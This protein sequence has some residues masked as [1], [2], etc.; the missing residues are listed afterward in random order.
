MILL[1]NEP[2][3]WLILRSS[4]LISNFN[5]YTIQSPG[6]IFFAS[7]QLGDLYSS[8]NVQVEFSKTIWNHFNYYLFTHRFCPILSFP[9]KLLLY[10]FLIFSLCITYFL[11]SFLFFPFL[12]SLCLHLGIFYWLPFS[13]NKVLIC[14]V[15]SNVKCIH[16]NFTFLHWT[17]QV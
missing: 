6:V 10:T 9:S 14:F 7:I 4:F 15:I 16:W 17:V 2:F 8:L 11:F 1:G 5:S 13:F 3:P 12:S